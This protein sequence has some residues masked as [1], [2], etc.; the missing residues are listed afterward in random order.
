VNDRA[1]CPNAAFADKEIQERVPETETIRTLRLSLN[2][3]GDGFV[4]AVADQTLLIFPG[5]SANRHTEK[6]ADRFCMS[7]SWKRPGR[8]V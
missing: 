2:L 4:E 5:N 3:L 6:S 8:W 1:I 7:P